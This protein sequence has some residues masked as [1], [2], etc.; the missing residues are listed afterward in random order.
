MEH[1]PRSITPE[2][3]E[4]A[5]HELLLDKV[6]KHIADG[7]LLASLPTSGMTPTQIMSV[8]DQMIMERAKRTLFGLEKTGVKNFEPKTACPLCGKPSP[9]NGTCVTCLDIYIVE[10]NKWIEDN[11]K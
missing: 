1:R 7:T 11:A 3:V 6:R 10:S 5:E 8:R 4:K 2:E 9:G